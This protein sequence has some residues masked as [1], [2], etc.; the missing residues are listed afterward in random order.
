MARSLRGGSVAA[1]D[2]ARIRGRAE[3]MLEASAFRGWDVAVL[4][5]DDERVRELNHKYRGKDVATDVLA[6]RFYDGPEGVPAPET[7][8]EAELRNLGDVVLGVPFIHR[9]S[10]ADG[11]A[12]DVRLDATLAHGLAHLMGHEHETDEQ[13]AVMLAAE[14]RL[15]AALG[16]E[17]QPLQSS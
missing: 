10:L 6:F 4:L 15:L 1:L 3:T 17:P 12:F 2:A 5:E 16:D 9:T 7:V 8:G 11:A 14:R 13:E